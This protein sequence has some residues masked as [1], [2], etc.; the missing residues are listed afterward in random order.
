M[1]IGASLL[2]LCLATRVAAGGE[3][4]TLPFTFVKNQI[5]VEAMVRVPALRL[6]AARGRL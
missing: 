6:A 3:G 2:I 1:R 5:V 4:R